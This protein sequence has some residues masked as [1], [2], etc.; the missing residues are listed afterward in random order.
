MDVSR[1]IDPALRHGAE[2]AAGGPGLP[3]LT[4]FRRDRTSAIEAFLYE[5]VVCLVLQGGKVTSIGEQSVAIGPGD[6]LV[7][8]H[9][10]PVVSRITEA[11][12]AA[13]Y[14][15]VILSIDLALV[16][17]LHADIVAA[18]QP[19][20][21]GPGR[22]LAAGPAEAAWVEPLARYLAL[23]E[24]PLDAAVLGPAVRRE[25]HYRLLRAPIGAMLRRLP[26]ADSHASRVARAIRRLRAEFRTPIGVAELART[27]GMGASAFHAHFKAVTGTTPLRYQKD[28]RLIEA[29][30]LLV[31]R[32][33]TVAEAAWA[34]GY[35]SPTHFSRDYSRKFGVAPSREARA[36]EPARRGAGARR[37]DA[38]RR[39]GAAAAG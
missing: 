2:T 8:S 12:P 4:V 34:V 33:H 36:V 17:D 18:R 6:A 5:P 19:E 11:C 30:S 26:V 23:A 39:A 29:R 28:L 25:I 1:L 35:E 24:A 32:R 37:R 13:P 10:L 22:A 7:V 31:D 27:A 16:R 15:A 20:P 38:G 9:D 14:L 21:A 3:G